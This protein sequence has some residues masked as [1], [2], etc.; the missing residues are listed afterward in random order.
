[1]KKAND[2]KNER[3]SVYIEMLLAFFV[4]LIILG[5]V[6]PSL[7]TITMNRKELLSDNIAN[8][9]LAKQFTKLIYNEQIDSSVTLKGISTI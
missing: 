6:I 2:K 5:F 4:W 8:E 7:M 3:G 1:M 9:I